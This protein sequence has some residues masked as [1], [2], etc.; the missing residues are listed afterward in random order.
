VPGQEQALGDSRNGEVRQEQGKTRSSALVSVEFSALRG[1]APCVTP[2][3]IGGL[4]RESAVGRV[5]ARMAAGRSAW[6]AA[7]IR[8]QVEQLIA[9]AGIVAAAAV[10]TELAEDLTA[11]AL[12]SCVP[13]LPRAGLPEHVRAWTS[14]PVLDGAPVSS[15]ATGCSPTAVYR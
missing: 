12:A 2:R 5:L 14:Q 11:R 8:G 3:P 15:R 9:G 10:R 6:N 13:L 1:R 7:D 4:D